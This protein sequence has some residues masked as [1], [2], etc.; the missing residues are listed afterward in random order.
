MA[1]AW[2]KKRIVPGYPYW[3][4][5][6]DTVPPSGELPSILTMNLPLA[7]HAVDVVPSD[8]TVHLVAEN[9]PAGTVTDSSS[10]AQ[11]TFASE[12][13]LLGS[14]ADAAPVLLQSISCIPAGI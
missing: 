14:F 5:T 10:N 8:V 3:F 2:S 12:L 11:S 13:T 9:V 4:S 6:M 7:I 1:V